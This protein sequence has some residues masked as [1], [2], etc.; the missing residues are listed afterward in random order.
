MLLQP[1]RSA[2]QFASDRGC[3]F[4]DRRV[5]SKVQQLMWL[6]NA[7]EIQPDRSGHRDAGCGLKS[8]MQQDYHTNILV[9]QL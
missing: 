1:R 3:V 2:P 6:D 5:N 8:H 9:E 7:D 4:V